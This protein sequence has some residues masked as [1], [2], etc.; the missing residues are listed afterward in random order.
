MSLQLVSSQPQPAP[1]Q[2]APMSDVAGADFDGHPDIGKLRLQFTEYVD[3]KGRQGGE[4]EE[5]RSADSYF[6]GYH[7]T[8]EQIDKY[9][10]RGQPT[11]TFNFIA[12]VL[13][14]TAGI[15]EKTRGDPKAFP[16]NEAAGEGAEIATQ[17]LRYVTDASQWG[18]KE[19][20]GL[21][22]GMVRGIAVAMLDTIPGDMGDQ[23]VSI[24]VIDGRTF[25][26]DPRSIEPDFSDVGSRVSRNG[27]PRMTLTS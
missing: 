27:Q 2:Q 13:N 6:H 12:D 19:I 21:L 9:N 16:R 18:D 11:I 3:A 20:D 17:C 25:F 4:I 5:Q 14:G 15:L 26:Y 24:G 1:P 7:Y 23:D 22:Q 8:K 10:D